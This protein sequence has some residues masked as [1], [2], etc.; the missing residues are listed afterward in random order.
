MAEKVNDAGGQEE[1]RVLVEV[2]SREEGRGPW[3]SRKGAQIGIHA[4]AH[5]TSRRIS[6]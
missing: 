2:L 6:S 1:R 5:P 3:S 4:A